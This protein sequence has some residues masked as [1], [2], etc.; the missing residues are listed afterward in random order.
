MHSALGTFGFI[1]KCQQHRTPRQAAIFDGDIDARQILR[2]HPPGADIHVPDFG[3]AH[4]A[5]GQPDG[6]AR[7]LQ[8]RMRAGGQQLGVV[9]GARR[10]DGVVRGGIG[11]PAPTVKNAEKSGTRHDESERAFLAK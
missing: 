7:S 9:G 11:T 2:H 10:R 1:Y 8:Q 3:V 6:A 5:L 4:L